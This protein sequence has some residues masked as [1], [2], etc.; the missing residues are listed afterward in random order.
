MNANVYE[1]WVENPTPLFQRFMVAT[2]Q[3][4]KPDDVMNTWQIPTLGQ[5]YLRGDVP[6]TVSQKIVRQQDN[7]LYWTVDV[8]YQLQTV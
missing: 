7:P 4:E 6:T 5:T 2:Q 3:I 1:L 8:T